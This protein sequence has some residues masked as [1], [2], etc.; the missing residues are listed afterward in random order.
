[1]V[2]SFKLLVQLAS[3]VNK[4]KEMASGKGAVTAKATAS[5]KRHDLS[6]T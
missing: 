1:M 4:E 6:S 2:Y 3:F 5:G